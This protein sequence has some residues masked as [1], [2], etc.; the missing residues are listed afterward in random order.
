MKVGWP[1][2][3][4]ISDSDSRGYRDGFVGAVSVLVGEACRQLVRG[5]SKNAAERVSTFGDCLELCRTLFCC[6]RP[7]QPAVRVQSVQS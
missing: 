4:V 7:T 1:D 3:C 2:L 5:N 6:S